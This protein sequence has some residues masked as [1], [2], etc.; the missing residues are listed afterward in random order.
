[1]ENPWPAIMFTFC[2]VRLW[3]RYK[4]PWKTKG[5][6]R[7]EAK[8][9]ADERDHAV[10]GIGHFRGSLEKSIE[11]NNQL[12]HDRNTAREEA[13]EER[14]ARLKLEGQRIQE[15][16]ALRH[17]TFG[18]SNGLEATLGLV[19]EFIVQLPDFTPDQAERG[20]V[21]SGLVKQVH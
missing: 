18:L 8:R 14:T 9:H 17:L 1:M 3:F 2:C 13:S 4:L 6:L 7:D 11:T 20:E 16:E 10:K 15:H 19:N 5:Y 21:I 12:I